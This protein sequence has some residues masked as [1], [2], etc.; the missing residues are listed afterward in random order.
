MML[1]F[2]P[3]IWSVREVLRE[4]SKGLGA[5]LGLR[6]TG[7]V[8]GASREPISKEML[9][10]VDTSRIVVFKLVQH[11]DHEEVTAKNRGGQARAPTSPQ[12]H[13]EQQQFRFCLFSHGRTPNKFHFSSKRFTFLRNKDFES[14]HRTPRCLRGKCIRIRAGHLWS[15]GCKQLKGKNFQNA[16][17][18]S[19]NQKGHRVLDFSFIYLLVT[20]NLSLVD[21]IK[22]QWNN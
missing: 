15:E 17:I 3:W 8:W 20:L 5:A 21:L 10:S 2:V 13:P 14:R 4:S 19:S 9:G 6:S 1:E 12:A 22:I 18:L 16:G 11:K 7:A